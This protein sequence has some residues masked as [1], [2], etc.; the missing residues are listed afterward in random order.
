VVTSSRAKEGKTTVVSNLAISLAELGRKTLLVD[1]DLPHPRL[2]DVFDQSN[3]CGLSDILCETNAVEFP[4]NTLIRRTAVPN[5]SLLAAGPPQNAMWTAPQLQRVSRLFRQLREEFDCVLVDTP[6]CLEF[7]EA[8]NL[9]TYADALVLVVQ[10]NCTDPRTAQA[11]L[12]R[13]ERDNSPV[14]GIILNRL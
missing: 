2:H 10:A 13:L 3:L 11:A 7:I 12:R 14:L 9:A 8:S 5:L 1:A 4:L 6:P